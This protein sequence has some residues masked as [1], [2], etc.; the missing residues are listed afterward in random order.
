M[1][2]QPLHVAA[3]MLALALVSFGCDPSDEYSD[4]GQYVLHNDL[5]SP[6]GLL[7]HHALVGSTFTLEVVEV[8]GAVG[9]VGA[10]DTELDPEGGGIK[11]ATRSGSGVV[12]EL[13]D[14]V[15]MVEAAGEGAVELADPGI[16]CPANDDILAELGPD[17][18]SVIG[19]APADVVGRWAHFP[20]NYIRGKGLSPGP[21]GVFPD[22]LG[23]PIDELRVVA[24][25]PFSATPALVR[26]IGDDEV[27]VR[28]SDINH[29]LTVPAHYDDLRPRGDDGKVFP[30]LHGAMAVGESFTSSVTILGSS[31]PLP[32]VRAVPVQSIQTLELI[33]IYGAGN[34]ER[35]WGPPNGVL[36][37]TRDGEGRRIVGAPVEYELTAGKLS[38][39][40][41][42][43]TLYL[44]DVCRRPPDAP[45]ARTA[46]IAA[47]LGEL[48][49]SVD[50]EWIALPD[51]QYLPDA[52]CVA[53]CACTS[54]NP[55]ESTPGLLAL[56]GL[57][58]VLRLRRRSS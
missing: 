50:L 5:G 18:W 51:D 16:S 30:E 44:G 57:G 49:A 26:L 47:S 36:A 24:N 40:P 46:S 48:E 9:V 21:Q 15:F 43:D 20:D 28:W 8:V 45:T 55:G 54:A 13:E 10:V 31:F 33:P 41:D 56:F 34:P 35:E 14:G 19:T 23:Q 12:V 17:R 11:C 3:A 38:F 32:V 52:E 58:L 29:V 6:L 42:S 2:K 7:S 37:I 25:S 27:E 1:V 39:G 22:I 53:S 4:N